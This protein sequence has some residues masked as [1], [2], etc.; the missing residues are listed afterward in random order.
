MKILN[1]W[2]KLNRLIIFFKTEVQKS[3]LKVIQIVKDPQENTLTTNMGQEIKSIEEQD[4]WK[5]ENMRFLKNELKAKDKFLQNKY[6]IQTK[7][8]QQQFMMHKIVI[9]IWAMIAKVISARPKL[10]FQ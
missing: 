5:D 10:S 2:A 3:V 9:N 4:E 1:T 6:L 7:I 8:Y